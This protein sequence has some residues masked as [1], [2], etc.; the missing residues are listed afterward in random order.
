MEFSKFKLKHEF[1]K[2]IKTVQNINRGILERLFCDTICGIIMNLAFVNAH[3]I[4]IPQPHNVVTGNCLCANCRQQRLQAAINQ[5]QLIMHYKFMNFLPDKENK[6]L[7]NLFGS[8]IKLIVQGKVY[9]H[10][11]LNGTRFTYFKSWAKTQ[12]QFQDF[13]DEE[14]AKFCKRVNECASVFD[15]WEIIAGN[16]ADPRIT[17]IDPR[18]FSVNQFYRAQSMDWCLSCNELLR[19]KSKKV[20]D[21]AYTDEKFEDI[22]RYIK[23]TGIFRDIEYDE[24]LAA[25]LGDRLQ[26]RMIAYCRRRERPNPY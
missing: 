5:H 6:S 9:K 11:S 26:R 7:D 21:P 4:T 15:K 17:E 23:D 20:D 25:G 10:R 16:L 24:T 19:T 14:M 12:V 1:R 22:F 18:R 2:A 8:T 3:L 13:T